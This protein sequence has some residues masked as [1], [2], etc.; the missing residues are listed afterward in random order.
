MKLILSLVNCLAVLSTVLWVGCQEP[1]YDLEL[2]GFEGL[3]QVELTIDTDCENE[4]IFIGGR[5]YRIP[6]DANGHATINDPWPIRR[7]HK[8]FLVMPTR[9]L[10]ENRDFRITESRWDMAST[11]SRHEDGSVRSTSNIDGS[12]LV[13]TIEYSPEAGNEE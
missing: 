6:L 1:G 9:R 3:T 12:K 8:T 5:V 10:I 11:T 2:E 13:M 4:P 7:F